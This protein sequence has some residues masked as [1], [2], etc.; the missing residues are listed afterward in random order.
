MSTDTDTNRQNPD[1]NVGIDWSRS[2]AATER[3]NAGVS[4]PES[5]P[6]Q[7]TSCT[8]DAAREAAAEIEFACGKCASG[9]KIPAIIQRALD[10]ATAELRAEN[11]ELSESL[12]QSE[13]IASRLNKE[14]EIGHS[15]VAA[16]DR[17][18]AELRWRLEELRK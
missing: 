2:K 8:T 13:H 3:E 16:K 6:A 14:V 9:D 5:T 17:E 4:L 18:I 11:S 12:K 7:S 1:A 10:A 15:V